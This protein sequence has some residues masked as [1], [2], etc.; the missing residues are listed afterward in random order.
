MTARMAIS[1]H[2]GGRIVARSFQFAVSH[3]AR[4]FKNF[5][6]FTRLSAMTP[7]PT[8]APCHRRHDS[9]SVEDHVV[10]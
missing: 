3:A 4:A 5:A 6:V 10:V 1:C 9:D 7:S 8:S 2:C